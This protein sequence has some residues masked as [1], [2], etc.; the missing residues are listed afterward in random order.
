[1][2]VTTMSV[3]AY[4]TYY[5]IDVHTHTGSMDPKIFIKKEKKKPPSIVQGFEKFVSRREKSLSQLQFPLEDHWT[6]IVIL[7]KDAWRFDGATTR[8]KGN[9]IFFSIILFAWNHF[10]AI[11]PDGVF[12]L[13]KQE[14]ISLRDARLYIHPQNLQHPCIELPRSLETISER[15]ISHQVH[16]SSSIKSRV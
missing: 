10:F 9:N 8:Y 15:K 3:T 13:S 2:C 7:I 14:L 1:M 16:T 6:W 12:N 4:R 5:I 11:F